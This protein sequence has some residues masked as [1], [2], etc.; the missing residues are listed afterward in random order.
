[1]REVAG[2]AADYLFKRISSSHIVSRRRIKQLFFL[3]VG[4]TMIN[5]V[6]YPVS[7]FG[8]SLTVNQAT[9]RFDFLS[10]DF[11]FLTLFKTASGEICTG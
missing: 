7:I 2:F 4:Y 10:L 11:D 6:K 1:M 5:W 9:L 3:G 8:L